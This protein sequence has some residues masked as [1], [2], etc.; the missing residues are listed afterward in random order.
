SM[1]TACKI[2]FNTSM[3][4]EA[5]HR[6]LKYTYLKRGL[7]ARIDHLCNTLITVPDEIEEDREIEDELGHQS[8]K[9]RLSESNS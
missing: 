5:Y 4:S 9:Y 3:M 2:P 8:G 7:V 1:G 6:T